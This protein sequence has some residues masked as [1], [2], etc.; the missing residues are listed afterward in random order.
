VI[1][2]LSLNKAEEGKGFLRATNEIS[3]GLEIRSAVG[4]FTLTALGFRMTG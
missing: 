4:S 2:T 3:D 1:L